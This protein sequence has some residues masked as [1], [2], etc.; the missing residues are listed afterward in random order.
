MKFLISLLL[1]FQATGLSADAF[2]IPYVL[3]LDESFF[4][5]ND[6]VNLV[7][8]NGRFLKKLKLKRGESLDIKMEYIIPC[9]SGRSR[10]AAEQR[11]EALEWNGS[12]YNFY[13]EDSRQMFSVPAITTDFRTV[14]IRA[15]SIYEVRLN[16]TDI[17]AFEQAQFR[18]LY[19]DF[20]SV[21]A[22]V[23]QTGIKAALEGG[24]SKSRNSILGHLALIRFDNFTA[25]EIASMFKIN[26][27]DTGTVVLD[28]FYDGKVMGEIKIITSDGYIRAIRY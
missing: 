23:A 4:M 12:T 26:L 17:S 28:R 11:T 25:Q 6:S 2:S 10:S 7:L 20:V 13:Y 27:P 24:S 9:F 19:Y 1:L 3:R 22:F 5:G 8:H 14:R 15:D 16:I 18:R 21:S